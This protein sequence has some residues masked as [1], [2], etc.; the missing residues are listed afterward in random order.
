[1]TTSDLAARCKAALQTLGAA[2]ATPEPRCDPPCA[3]G[4][5]PT[6]PTD[7]AMSLIQAR[8]YVGSILA[9]MATAARNGSLGSARTVA[10]IRVSADT[11]TVGLRDV[12]ERIQYSALLGDRYLDMPRHVLQA[13]LV[14]LIRRG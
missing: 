1:M 6:D 4:A 11:V 8:A 10:G 3:D 14:E 2:L 7:P 13:W 5:D 9:D 12:R